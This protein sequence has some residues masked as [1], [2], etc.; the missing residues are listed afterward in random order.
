MGRPYQLSIV[1]GQ[2]TEFQKGAPFND[3]HCFG[4]FIRSWARTR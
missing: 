1:F 4:Q 3:M 2:E